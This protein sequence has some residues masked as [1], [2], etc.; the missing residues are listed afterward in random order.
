MPVVEESEF[1]GVQFEPFSHNIRM[2]IL[3]SILEIVYH[4]KNYYRMHFKN[5]TSGYRI[6]I[7][8]LL[9]FIS[10]VGWKLKD[11]LTSLYLDKV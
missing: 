5:L 3:L 7:L 4:Q 10:V 8:S 9:P 2:R 1:S 6:I 11:I